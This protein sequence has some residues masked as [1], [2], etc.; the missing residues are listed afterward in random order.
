MLIL[1][2]DEALGAS[3]F[4]VRYTADFLTSRMR[5]ILVNALE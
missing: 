4:I 3:R 2:L 5:A 1:I